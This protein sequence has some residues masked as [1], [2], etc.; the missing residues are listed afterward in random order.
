[1]KRDGVRGDWSF[2]ETSR[3]KKDFEQ[4]RWLET[5]TR[6]IWFSHGQWCASNK[7]KV[8]SAD[9]SNAYLQDKEVG[10]IILYSIPKGGI[11]EEGVEEDRREGIATRQ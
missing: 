6:T 9:I 7:V 11:L 2:V 4:V 1:M 5:W 8:R 3:I 10:R